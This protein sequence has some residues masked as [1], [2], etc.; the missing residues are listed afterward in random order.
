MNTISD[1]ANIIKI[2]QKT[3]DLAIVT[4]QNKTN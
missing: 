1:R 4:L 3:K 2:V